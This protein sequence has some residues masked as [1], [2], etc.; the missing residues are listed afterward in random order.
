MIDNSLKE[1]VVFKDVELGIGTW[2]CGDRLYW[3]YGQGYN[4]DDLRRVFNVSLLE[5]ITFF[6]TAEI[7]GQGLS[8]S[9]L[10]RFLKETDKKVTIASKFMPFPWKIERHALL[11]SLKR[12]I[13]RL[14]IPTI[15][16]YQMHFPLPPL[17]IET[18]ME[19]MIEAYQEGLISAIG[20]SNYDR[21]QMQRAYDVLIQQG[22]P[23]A[24]NQVEYNLLDRRVERNGLLK[25]CHE[26]GVKLIAYSPLAMGVLS[27]KYTPE[28]PLKGIRGRRYPK[29]TLQNIEP[30][31]ALMR[32]IGSDHDGKTNTQVALN[33][34]IC[35][36]TLPIPGAKT[37]E[38]VR[39][40][41]GALSWKLTE[42]EVALLDDVSD[43]LE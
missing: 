23:L 21:G 31:L 25:H 35:K 42:A 18:W 30:L 9:I 36:G 4:V 12:S 14:G 19:S 11:R 8:E 10:G 16:L 40:N 3:S 39:Q 27:G 7:Y 13:A 5:N 1:N 32:K 2:S 28:N 34:L 17:T 22:L 24:S 41:I 6:D 33:W 29:K 20:V 43:R 26:L 15:D 38:Q 37:E